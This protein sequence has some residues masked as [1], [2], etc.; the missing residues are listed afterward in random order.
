MTRYCPSL[1]VLLL[2]LPACP[3]G[4]DV[5]NLPPGQADGGGNLPI[6]YPDAS[7]STI[8]TNTD[9]GAPPQL[10]GGPPP[11]KADATP[12]PDLKQ[13]PPTPDTGTPP[14][15]GVGGPCPCSGGLVCVNNACRA[16]CNA[17]TDPCKV[18]SNCPATDACLKTN[19]GYWVCLPATA[20]P[21]QAC[22]TQWCPVNYV[23]GGLG[24]GGYKCL[25]TCTGTGTPCGTGGTCSPALNGCTFCSSN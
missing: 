19:L 4:M 25:P 8:S 17:P 10:D 5:G 13:A 15:P 22:G 7:P 2:A 14:I 18:A 21:G 20:Q 16:K 6:T 12:A 11:P 3:G 24:S 1:L 9:L 23:C